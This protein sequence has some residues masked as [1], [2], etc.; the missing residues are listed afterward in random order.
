[1]ENNLSTHSGEYEYLIKLEVSIRK[2]QQ[3]RTKNSQ[4]ATGT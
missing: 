1:M 2:P 4:L 3:D